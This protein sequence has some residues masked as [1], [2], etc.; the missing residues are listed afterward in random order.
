MYIVVG[1]PPYTCRHGSKLLSWWNNQFKFKTSWKFLLDLEEFIESFS[2]ETWV[3][4]SGWSSTSRWKCCTCFYEEV[5]V[6]SIGGVQWALSYL[7]FSSVQF[8]SCHFS[9]L[10]TWVGLQDGHYHEATLGF[11]YIQTSCGWGNTVMNW[12]SWHPFVV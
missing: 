12:M 4:W 5:N 7:D 9:S 10:Q 2:C 11:E 1:S 6:K 8:M 3:S